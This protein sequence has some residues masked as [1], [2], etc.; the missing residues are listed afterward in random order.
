MK[1]EFLLL[2]LWYPVTDNC[3]TTVAK[4]NLHSVSLWPAIF[5]VFAKMLTSTH[6]IQDI[7]KSLNNIQA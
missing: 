5:C 4:V 2:F 7:I 6:I 3:A 1:Q